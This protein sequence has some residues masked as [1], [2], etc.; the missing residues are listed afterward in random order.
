M[1]YFFELKKTGKFEVMGSVCFMLCQYM[2]PVYIDMVLLDNTTGWKLGWFY[3]DNPKPALPTWSGYVS[4]L[5]LEWVNQL[6]S[7]ENDTIKPLLEDL[8]RLKTEGL[9]G[10]AA[11]ISFSWRLL[12]PI[13]DRVHLAYECWG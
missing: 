5:V 7:W 8:E 4:V 11:G 6:T 9:T 1:A 13:Q 12:Q 10:S 3:L 2:K